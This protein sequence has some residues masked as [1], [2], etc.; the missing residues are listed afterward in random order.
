MSKAK[1]KVFF[2][3]VFILG[4]TV[5][6]Y[7]Q[8]VNDQCAN[9]ITLGLPSL[10]LGTVVNATADVAPDC[11]YSPR[12]GVW[13][14]VVGTGNMMTATTCGVGGSNANF[15]SIISIY[16]GAC[17]AMN[18]EAGNDDACSGLRST[19]SWNSQAGTVYSILVHPYSNASPGDFALAVYDITVDGH[20]GQSNYLGCYNGYCPSSNCLVLV[21]NL[22]GCES[23]GSIE[24]C[25][26]IIPGCGGSYCDV[27]IPS[28]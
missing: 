20:I 26:C 7:A 9:A 5:S 18:C 24:Y 22:N 21:P 19:V 2:V 3:T 1:L 11:P 15:D 12:N 6:V 14:T 27:Y 13:Y 25:G 23:I 28:R 8:P 16:T 17:G 4:L 10:T